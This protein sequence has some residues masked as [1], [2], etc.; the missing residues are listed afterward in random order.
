MPPHARYFGCQRCHE[1][2]YTSCQ[3]SR[4]YDSLYRF[5]ARNMGQDFATVKRL[6]NRIGEG[7][8]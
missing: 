4:K 6:A 5:M 3:E 2:T 8:L 1:L 7:T